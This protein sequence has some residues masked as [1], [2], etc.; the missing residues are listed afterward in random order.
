MRWHCT[1]ISIDHRLSGIPARTQRTSDGLVWFDGCFGPTIGPVLG[2]FIVDFA[3]W[4]FVFV[5]AVPMLM[6]GSI[7]AWIFVPGRTATTVRSPLNIGSFFMIIGAFMLFLNGISYGQRDGWDTDPVFFMLFMSLV[8]FISFLI[9]EKSWLK[10][11][12]KFLLPYPK[13]KIVK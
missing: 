9:R 6:V 3:Q 8:L 11:G 7:M 4:R 12:G 5:A 1:T 13:L 2:G 10:N